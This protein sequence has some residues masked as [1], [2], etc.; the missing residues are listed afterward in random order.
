[1][2]GGYKANCKCG[3]ETQV[4]SGSTRAMRDGQC[5]KPALCKDCGKLGSSLYGKDAPKCKFCQS[6]NIVSYKDSELRADQ[7]A[8]FIELTNGLYF[9]PQCKEF[10]L[11]FKDTGTV[12]C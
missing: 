6:A 12:F 7:S 1:M 2:A 9:C 3:Y 8:K 11:S 4:L 10:G 5:Y